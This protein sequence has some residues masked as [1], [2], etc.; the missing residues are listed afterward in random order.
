VHGPFYASAKQVIAI[1]KNAIVQ[2]G[3]AELTQMSGLVSG[4]MHI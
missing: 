3:V 2:F 4:K 1:A